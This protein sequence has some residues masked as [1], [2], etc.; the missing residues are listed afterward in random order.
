MGDEYENMLQEKEIVLKNV[1]LNW[2]ILQS[3]LG[4]TYVYYGNDFP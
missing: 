1:V 4:A 3:R 2:N